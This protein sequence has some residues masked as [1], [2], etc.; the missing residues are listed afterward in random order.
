MSRLLLI[1]NALFLKNHFEHEL[2]FHSRKWRLLIGGDLKI[3]FLFLFINKKLFQILLGAILHLISKQSEIHENT[4][5]FCDRPPDF[6]TFFGRKEL[7]NFPLAFSQATD[8]FSEIFSLR[9]CAMRGN[10]KIHPHVNS[11]VVTCFEGIFIAKEEEEE[12]KKLLQ[13]CFPSSFAISSHSSS[14]AL[15]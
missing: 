6:I 8:D 11:H 13:V 5:D 2:S 1:K 14:N 9:T 12:E 15:R 4:D 7:R 10:A 3:V